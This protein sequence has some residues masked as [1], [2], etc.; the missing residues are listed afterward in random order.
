MGFFFQIWKAMFPCKFDQSLMT[1]LGFMP[2]VIVTFY[3]YLPPKLA[4]GLLERSPTLTLLHLVQVGAWL[5]FVLKKVHLSWE[6]S[7]VTKSSWTTIVAWFFKGFPPRVWI[8]EDSISFLSPV[9]AT[10][11]STYG[12]IIS[13]FYVKPAQ[14][15]TFMIF[16]PLRFYVK[17]I[18][19]IL[20]VQ[21][22]PF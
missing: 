13:D 5:G 10:L 8:P 4:F 16:L 22:L 19:G 9:S 3:T 20:E 18:L 21:N 6:D 7:Q 1:S 11:G 17:S 14:C 2:W 12:L 15:E